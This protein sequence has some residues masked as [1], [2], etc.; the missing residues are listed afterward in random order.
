M[1][2]LVAVL[3]ALATFLA[4]WPLIQGQLLPAQWTEFR[5]RVGTGGNQSGFARLLRQLGA[6][7]AD[8]LCREAGRPAGLTGSHVIMLQ[9]LVAACSGALLG[10]AGHPVL[11]MA[12]GGAAWVCPRLALSAARE[13][14]HQRILL[15]LPTFLDLWGLLLGSGEGLETALVEITQRHPD[16]LA[17]AE[18]RRVLDRVAASGLFGESL[19]TVARESGSEALV[20]VA[21]QVRQMA[22]GG[23]SPTRELARIAHRLR[24]DRISRLVQSAGMA[25]VLGIFPKLLTVFLSLLPVVAS[26]VLTV[27]DQL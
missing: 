22:E 2:G 4:L 6:A 7:E 11:G 18:M 23:G 27:I 12:V 9:W 21:E 10:T 17:S 14:R 20:G 5:R 1:V 16:W 15:E 8:R 19:V 25:A 13:A 26:I 24:N 3:A